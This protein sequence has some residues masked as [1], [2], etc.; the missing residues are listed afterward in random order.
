MRRVEQLGDEVDSVIVDFRRVHQADAPASEL[1]RRMCAAA[2]ASGRTLLLTGL[3]GA[4]AGLRD[5]VGDL[6]AGG[7]VRVEADV[8][9]ALEWC[10]DR[11]LAGLSE[12]ADLS[13]FSLARLEIFQGLSR[14]EH[15]LLESIAQPMT[16][17]KGEVILR[18]GDPARV[19]FVLVRGS[20]RIALTV[21]GE[22]MRRIAGIGP[23]MPFGEMALFDGGRRS[24][25]VIA[26]ESV[27]CYGISVESLREISVTHPNIMATILANLAR[28]LSERLRRANRE[29]RALD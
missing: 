2:G 27:V 20:V 13:E 10:E 22:R 24:A 15:R 9:A 26:E 29:I 23:G 3:G 16:F 1:L 18:E 14:E 25:N 5:A 7:S 4:L 19:F 28:D 11:I 17:D 8:D 6:A 12:G 21:A